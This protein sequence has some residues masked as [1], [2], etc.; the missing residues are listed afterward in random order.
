MPGGRVTKHF[1]KQHRVA[2][3]HECL[4]SGAKAVLVRVFIYSTE[5]SS[6]IRTV[7]E[8]TREEPRVLIPTKVNDGC[9]GHM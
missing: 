2:R 7:A 9:T 8:V 3:M 6:L 5:R 1:P 4:L